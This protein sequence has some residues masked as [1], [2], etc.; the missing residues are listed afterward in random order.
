M[1]LL[2]NHMQPSPLACAIVSQLPAILAEIHHLLAEQ[3]P[4]Y[5]GFLAAN[6]TTVLPAAEHF[7]T[8]LIHVTES[9]PT[10][11]PSLLISGREQ[12]LFEDLGRRH[13]RDQQDITSLLAA[14]R[15]GAVVAWRHLVPAALYQR[16]AARALAGLATT[17]FTTIDELSS[18][19]LRGYSQA[20]VTAGHPRTRW[21]DELAELLLS[22]RADPATVRAAAAR[23]AWLLPNQAAIILIHPDNEL[24]RTLLNRLGPACLRLRRAQTLVAIMPDP[25]GAGQRIHLTQTLRG[26]AAVIGTTVALNKLPTSLSLAQ[27]ALRLRQ[28]RVLTGDPLFIDRHLPAMVAHHDQRLLA[29]VRHRHLAP[30]SPLP[31]P[32][33]HRLS[34]TLRSWLMHMGNC[35]AVAT[36]LHV[37]PQTVRYRLSQLH[38]LFGA[39]LDDPTTRAALLLGLAWDPALAATPDDPAPPDASHPIKTR[40]GDSKPMP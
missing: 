17:L 20:Q 22:D 37:H 19:S 5:A 28:A 36:E 34:Q 21:R 7:L 14:Y 3:H 1:P 12:A 38:E 6:R 31:T 40:P 16:I 27:Q 8:R 9:D 35:T 15:I 29:Q 26:A 4:D 33:R 18:A 30:L 25:E 24:A 13:Y 10:A 23:A 11:P 2:D 32:T 39:A